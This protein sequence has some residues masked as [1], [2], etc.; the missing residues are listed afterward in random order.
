MDA[1]APLEIPRA[2]AELPDPREA[3]VRHALIDILTIALFAVICGADDWVA[4]VEYAVAKESW[5][6]TILTLPCGI[7]S[8]D[9]FS[10]V[11]A[12]LDPDK[13]EV[14]F[15]KW[16]AGLV[17]MS[18][19]KLTNKTLSIDGKSLRR[20]FEHAWDKSG[21]AHLVSAFVQENQLCFAQLK[22]NGKGGELDAIKEL[23]SMLDLKG[24]TVTIDA[25]GCQVEIAQIIHQAKA[26]YL[27]QLK[28]NQPTLL[29]QVTTLFAEAALEQFKGFTHDTHTTVNGGHGRIETRTIHVLWDIRHLGE[30]AKPW[31]GL[32]SVV[33]IKS[34]R[35]TGGKEV[36]DNHYYISSLNRRHKAETF[37]EKARGHWQIENNLHWQL[38]VSFSEDN[39]RNRVGHGAENFSRLARIALTLLKNE[40]TTKCGIKN[41]RKKCGWS[42]D[43]LLKVIAG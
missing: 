14:C 27:L 19:G 34:T 37:L 32:K 16:I 41:K 39:K 21:M 1:Q 36:I 42:D 4:V 2:F 18:G 35:H 10:R 28:E 43:Y 8:H 26:D 17:E 31:A 24:A 38:D 13:F 30:A 25:L 12:K 7:A 5:L 22:T 6:K 15:R 3:N 29:A 33:W 11:F 23:L 9:T 20:S 40:T